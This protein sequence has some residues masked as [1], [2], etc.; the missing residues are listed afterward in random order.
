MG[1]MAVGY[2]Q[3]NRIINDRD[4]CQARLV[5]C[6]WRV[7]SS[8]QW[9]Q[10]L[11]QVWQTSRYK[12]LI[13]CYVNAKRDKKNKINHNYWQNVKGGVIRMWWLFGTGTWLPMSGSAVFATRTGILLKI[14]FYSEFYFTT[15]KIRTQLNHWMSY[16]IFVI[17]VRHLII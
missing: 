12:V 1:Q 3:L 4:N 14:L 15:N 16:P 17:L 10:F 9:R 13:K 8:Q 7:V 2:I 6:S 11:W 5:H